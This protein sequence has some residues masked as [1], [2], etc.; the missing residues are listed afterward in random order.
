MERVNF[1]IQDGQLRFSSQGGL[2]G[3]GGNDYY[4]YHH[5]SRRL[6]FVQ[7]GLQTY[8]DLTPGMLQAAVEQLRSQRDQLQQLLDTTLADAAPA[9][10]KA[11]E[12]ALATVNLALTQSDAVFSDAPLGQAALGE[13]QNT[14]TLDGIECV[15]YTAT[16]YQSELE[17]CFASAAA[18]GL[19]GQEVAVMQAFQQLLAEISG[20]ANLYGLLPG[21]LPLAASH[22]HLGGAGSMTTLLRGVAREPLPRSHFSIPSH[23]RSATSPE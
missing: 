22:G 21:H 7:P 8:Y 1:Y 11:I 16:L 18:L 4:L 14:L 10:R 6:R 15:V 23:Y 9:Q 17:V 2:V 20:V 5:D 13:R 3:A 12:D 19:S